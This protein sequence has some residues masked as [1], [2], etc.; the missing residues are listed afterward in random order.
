MSKRSAELCEF[1]VLLYK[2]P[3]DLVS[4]EVLPVL[5]SYWTYYSEW[6]ALDDPQNRQFYASG[7]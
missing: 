1:E 4:K 3:S 5:A 2:A 7:I 6:A